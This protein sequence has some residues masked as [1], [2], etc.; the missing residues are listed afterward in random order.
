MVN[1][2]LPRIEIEWPPTYLP[3]LPSI[4]CLPGR[5][6]YWRWGH[7]TSITEAER[8]MFHDEVHGDNQA[9][10]AGCPQQPKNRK[11]WYL[12]FCALI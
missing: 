7:A 3:R 11:L 6:K 8:K 9:V 4:E 2:N 5:V 10:L 1:I 12:S